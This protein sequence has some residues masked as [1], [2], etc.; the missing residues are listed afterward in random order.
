MS[1]QG[2]E[3][4]FVDYLNRNQIP[5][6]HTVLPPLSPRLTP[7]PEPQQHRSSVSEHSMES[8]LSILSMVSKEQLSYCPKS[9]QNTTPPPENGLGKKRSFAC[10]ECKKVFN[11]KE[12]LQ[13]HERVHT[14]VRPFACKYPGCGKTFSRCDNRD[15]HHQ[16]HYK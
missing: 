3:S 15:T 5:M 10:K 1:L 14:G 12:H 4:L 16:T 2:F 11:R 9:I 6:I 8:N 13:R 7:E